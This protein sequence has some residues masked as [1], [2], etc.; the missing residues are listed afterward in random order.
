[1]S[2]VGERNGMDNMRPQGRGRGWR[3]EGAGMLG[4]EWAECD[5]W[6]KPLKEEVRLA[7]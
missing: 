6:Y 4:R 1:M 2:G 7:G 5:E 3:D